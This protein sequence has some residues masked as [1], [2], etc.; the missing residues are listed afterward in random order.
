MRFAKSKTGYLLVCRITDKL[1]SEAEECCDPD[2]PGR[3]EGEQ[4]VHT[5]STDT[6]ES[7]SKLQSEDSSSHSAEYPG[8]QK[9]HR[10]VIMY[11]S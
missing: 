1:V 9:L 11:C 8:S 2:L 6:E 4:A 7:S 10:K 5:H 3:S